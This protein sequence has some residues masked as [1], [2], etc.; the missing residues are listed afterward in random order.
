MRFF[1]ISLLVL[2]Q[3]CSWMAAHPQ[4]EQDLE[5]IAEEVVEDAIKDV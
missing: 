4:V 2:S 5:K 1:L 3:A